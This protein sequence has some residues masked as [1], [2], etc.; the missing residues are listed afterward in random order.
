MTTITKIDSYS[1]NITYHI[2]YDS[3]LT[4]SDQWHFTYT[5]ENRV[6]AYR[7]KA[8]HYV[9]DH[10]VE[11]AKPKEH[12]SIVIDND[13]HINYIGSAGINIVFPGDEIKKEKPEL[14]Y[15][16]ILL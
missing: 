4:L 8:G 2:D 12:L 13:N 5:E 3:T 11:L 6:N 15:A 16:D 14:S 10:C 9:Y 1:Q 7:V